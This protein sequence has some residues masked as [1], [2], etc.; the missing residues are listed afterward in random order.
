[1]NENVMK[2]LYDIQTSINAINEYL[3]TERNFNEFDKNRMLKKAVEREFEIIGEAIKRMFQIDSE[4]A[5]T[6]PRKIIDLRNYLAHGYDT[7]DY[8][9][10]W[11]IISRHLP[12]LEKE[13][14]ELIKSE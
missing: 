1:M 5:I 12:I 11:G 3:G 10:L 7:I 9:T 4:I 6:T 14:N 8:A 2:F 13:V